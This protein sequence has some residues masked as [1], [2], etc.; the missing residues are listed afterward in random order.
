MRGVTKLLLGTALALLLAT[1]LA[2]CGGDD[3]DDSTARSTATTTER[4]APATVPEDDGS[5]AKEKEPRDDSGGSAG[6]SDDAPSGGS[7]DSASGKDSGS[8]GG[9]SGGA[10]PSPEGSES[11]RVPGGDNSVQDFGDEADEEEREAASKVV[12][13]FL[14]ARAQGNWGAVCSYMA[15]AALKPIKQLGSRA[16][17]LSGKDCPEL[18][19]MLT[20][21]AS[22]STRASTIGSGIDSLRFEGERGFALYHGTDGKDYF[23]PLINEGGEWKIG[24][25]APS[26]LP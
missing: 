24:A 22:A 26:E 3:T 7:D 17:Q 5:A 9:G 15:A 18:L 23:I 14:R 20:G 21:S 13:G 1:G 4:T 12:V 11:F 19:E 10:N 25:L 16:P 8:S 2:A 6:G